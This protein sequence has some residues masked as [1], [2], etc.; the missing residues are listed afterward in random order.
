[1]TRK[2]P[3]VKRKDKKLLTDQIVAQI[4]A[5]SSAKWAG[6]FTPDDPEWHE[7][8]SKRIGG[9]EV[10]AIVGASKYESAYSL[11]AKKLGLISDEVSDNEFM[12]W[13]RALEPVVIDRF[14]KDHQDFDVLRDMGTW[15]HNERDYHLA[16][17]DAIYQKPS[18]NKRNVKLFNIMPR[19]RKTFF[20]IS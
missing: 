16:N 10:G 13:G 12:Y 7:L 1:V 14:A 18:R 9:S 15:V 17:P 5:R 11:W 4:E 3:A 6:S 20:F 2:P 19:E 8:R